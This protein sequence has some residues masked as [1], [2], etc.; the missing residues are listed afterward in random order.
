VSAANGDGGLADEMF[1]GIANTVHTGLPGS[2][3]P[4]PRDVDSVSVTITPPTGD[5]WGR[6]STQSHGSIEP[7]QNNGDSLMMPGTTADFTESGAGDGAAGHF[8]RRPWQQP[9]GRP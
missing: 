6:V 1:P 7:G 8:K 2:A 9:D 3:Q 4:G 5:P